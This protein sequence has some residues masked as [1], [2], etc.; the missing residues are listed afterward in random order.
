MTANVF[1]GVDVGSTTVKVVVLDEERTLLAWRYVRSNGRPRVVLVET[2]R[3]LQREIGWTHVAGAQ[4][5]F[6]FSSNIVSYRISPGERSSTT[7]TFLPP[8]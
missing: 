7:R 1:L 2:V 8:P 4:R 6:V 5:S 3:E